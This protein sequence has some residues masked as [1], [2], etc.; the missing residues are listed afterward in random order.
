MKESS[1]TNRPGIRSDSD[2][3]IRV[4]NAAVGGTTMRSFTV[5]APIFAAA[6]L[7]AI[8][9]SAAAQ[10][11]YPN[12]PIRFIVPYP[13]GGTTGTV[14]RL[15]APKLTELLGQPVIVDHRPGASTIIGSEAVAKAPSDGY[16]VM[17]TATTH[18][19]IPHLLPRIPYDAIRDF[20]PIASLASTELVMVLHPSV[21]ANSLKEFI[22][23]AKS[24]PGRLNY[25]SSS[26][27]SP[28]HLAAASFDIMAGVNMQHIPYKGGEPAIADLLGGQVQL[29]FATPVTVI[30]FIRSARLKALAISG[31]TRLPGL[32]Q[33]PTFA[34]AG[35]P[36]FEAKT[37]YGVIGPAG[38]PR[39]IIDRL[40]SEIA[41]ILVMP[42]LKETLSTQG[43]DPF[44]STPD[45]FAAL[46]K[47][48]MAKYGKVIKTANIRLE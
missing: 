14:T 24:K 1:A 7:I 13:P 44:I 34:E 26:T 21:E 17:L 9:A 23:L 41:K 30:G 40:S 3:H 4:I 10:Q 6:V 37:W 48:D 42:D 27:G 5:L 45:Q 33:V 8:A 35:L 46:M 20:A 47:A 43:L 25:A 16:T 22:A 2:Q 12:K 39:P 31:E 15:V 32:P 11:A 29:Y 19:I 36:G 28:T 18:I 38:T